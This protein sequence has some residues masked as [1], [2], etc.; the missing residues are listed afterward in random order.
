MWHV[1]IQ[2]QG[3]TKPLN[4]PS[5]CPLSPQKGMAFCQEHCVVA[6]KAGLPTG[7]HDFL[8]CCSTDEKTQ[9]HVFQLI[10]TLC[11]VSVHDIYKTQGARAKFL[12]NNIRRVSKEEVK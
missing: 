10:I 9:V 4:Y 6:T 11:T 1:P 7:L 3:F 5:I 2:V 8:K 12:R